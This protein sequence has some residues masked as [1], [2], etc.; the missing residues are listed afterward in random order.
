MAFS[1]MFMSNSVTR[2][3]EVEETLAAL[4]LGPTFKIDRAEV[5]EG[6]KAGMSKFFVHYEKFTAIKVREE[7]EEFKRRKEEGEVD[8]RPKRIVYNVTRD[9]KER[10]WQIFLCDTPDQRAFKEMQKE[11]QK[12]FA[13]R[14]E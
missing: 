5:T 9:G 10:Y 12:E 13:P 14:V 2:T 1:F 4:N 8:V 7:L 6:S 11:L 3:A